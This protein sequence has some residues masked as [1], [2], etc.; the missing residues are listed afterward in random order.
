MLSEEGFGE[1]DCVV[2]GSVSPEDEQEMGL[3]G[4]HPAQVV[5]RMAA[6]ID[7]LKDRLA[8]VP[9]PRC[10]LCKHYD[11]TGGCQR[12]EVQEYIADFEGF[13]PPPSFGCVLWEAK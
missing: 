13:Y 3:I 6:R 7:D 11:P 12:P 1:L 4:R 5:C 8:R 9:V 10:V 2:H